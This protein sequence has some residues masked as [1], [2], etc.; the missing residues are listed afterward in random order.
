MTASLGER[1]LR[2]LSTLAPNPPG[3]AA[4]AEARQW[5]AV[6]ESIASPREEVSRPASHG[7]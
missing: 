4:V 5:D 7:A 3:H 1:I 2:T 6:L